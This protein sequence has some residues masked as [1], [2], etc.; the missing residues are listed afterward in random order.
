MMLWDTVWRQYE[1]MQSVHTC[2][3]GEVNVVTQAKH[4]QHKSAVFQY[5]RAVATRTLKYA[6][7]V[8]PSPT[9]ELHPW[10][11][12]FLHDKKKV[13]SFR[14]SCRASCWPS[15]RT[16]HNPKR[17]LL[18]DT[19]HVDYSDDNGIP[20]QR[21][22]RRVYSRLVDADNRLFTWSVSV[23]MLLTRT[24]SVL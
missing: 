17:W 9:R 7:H 22:T 4:T 2:N 24:C 20:W 12:C 23:N 8:H 6:G 1:E 10:P 15:W 13:Q 16:V 5:T 3:V 21:N 18:C 19:H 14:I 11:T